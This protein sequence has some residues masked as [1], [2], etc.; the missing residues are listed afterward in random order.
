MKTSSRFE[1]PFYRIVMGCLIIL[2]G[3]E[4]I[5]QGDVPRSF[6]TILIVI[7]LVAVLLGAFFERGANRKYDG[8]LKNVLLL[9]FFFIA[10]F[11]TM[12]F[13]AMN[14]ILLPPN[15]SFILAIVI[16]GVPIGIN[17]YKKI[18]TK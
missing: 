7:I 14:G 5:S 4:V 9:L 16:F 11:S 12:M 3:L 13:L 1:N 6:G 18:K 15:A 10:L 17:F 8:D 2:L